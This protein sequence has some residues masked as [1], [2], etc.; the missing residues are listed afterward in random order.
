VILRR[1]SIFAGAFSLEAAST[2][3]ASPE[4]APLEVVD[5]LS[6]LVAK[7]LVTAE[8]EGPV[9]RYRLLDTTRSYAREKL[10]ENGERDQQA[11]RHAEYYRNLFE[12]AEA[13]WERRPTTESLPD[14]GR[15]IDDVRVALDW[16]LS[17]DGDASVGVVLTAASVPL[18]MHL[19]LIQECQGRIERAFAALAVGGAG[20][21]AVR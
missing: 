5:G 21:R 7:S 2:V 20:M 15:Q 4:L 19:S 9:A 17:P 1:L 11:R 10:E 12:Q 13:E 16:A 18:W 3:A 8:V 14:Y 6:N